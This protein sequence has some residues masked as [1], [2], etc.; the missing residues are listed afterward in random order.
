[1]QPKCNN[2]HYYAN[3]RTGPRGYGLRK[4]ASYFCYLPPTDR[5]GLI[6]IE[7][8]IKHGTVIPLKITDPPLYL[9]NA[10]LNYCQIVSKGIILFLLLT[11]HKTLGKKFKTVHLKK[12]TIYGDF[13]F[14]NKNC[15]LSFDTML[16]KENLLISVRQKQ[17]E[18]TEWTSLT[19]SCYSSLFN[20]YIFRRFQ[21]G[22]RVVC[23]E[24][25]DED[26]RHI[27]H[28]AVSV[29]RDVSV[30]KD[31]PEFLTGMASGTET[32]NRNHR[33]F[34]ALYPSRATRSGLSGSS[35]L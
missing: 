7:S 14:N 26:A 35:K 27:F 32:R 17:A 9:D 5:G 34:P 25:S 6:P 19:R 28:T 18:I 24:S 30:P 31:F 13:I 11:I 23:N 16:S 22:V 4:L 12:Q 29:N 21:D 3:V 15:C 33:D 2:I 10:T 8:A 1:M 20:G